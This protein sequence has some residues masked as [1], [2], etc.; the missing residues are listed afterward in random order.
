[1]TIQR[2]LVNAWRGGALAR[3]EGDEPGAARVRVRL[4]TP[5]SALEIHRAGFRVAERQRRSNQ[6]ESDRQE[7][8][9]REQV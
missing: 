6:R 9:Q 8:G 2:L 4:D 5:G 1:M 7:S 3:T